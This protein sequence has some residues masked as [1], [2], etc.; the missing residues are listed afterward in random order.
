MANLNFSQRKG[1]SKGGFLKAVLIALFIMLILG[2][3]NVNASTFTTL[4]T[5]P[6]NQCECKLTWLN[7]CNL[8]VIILI[9]LWFVNYY[10]RKEQIEKLYFN[11][12]SLIAKNKL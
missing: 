7:Y 9:P 12:A 3:G 2:C 8:A 10:I 1:K 11:I 6:A 5:E 4:Y